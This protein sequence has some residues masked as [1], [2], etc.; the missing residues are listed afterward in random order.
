MWMTWTA[1]AHLHL[2]Q[3]P[4]PLDDQQNNSE[5]PSMGSLLIE[6]ACMSQIF[7]FLHMYISQPIAKP[8]DEQKEKQLWAVSEQ[9][10]LKIFNAFLCVA[11]LTYILKCRLSLVHLK[12]WSYKSS[13]RCGSQVLGDVLTSSVTQHDRR[14]VGGAWEYHRLQENWGW[15]LSLILFFF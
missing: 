1:E 2:P 15:S 14:V 13:L 12:S 7:R 6:N 11:W 3:R 4:S 8:P 5:N 10:T 9:N